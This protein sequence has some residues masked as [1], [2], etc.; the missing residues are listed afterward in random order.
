[1]PHSAGLSLVATEAATRGTEALPSG[2]AMAFRTLLTSLCPPPLPSEP[3]VCEQIL[4]VLGEGPLFLV[5]CQVR[6]F[7]NKLFRLC[8]LVACGFCELVPLDCLPSSPK[9]RAAWPV[10]HTSCCFAHTE[11]GNWYIAL[12]G[13]LGTMPGVMPLS[14]DLQGLYVAYQTGIPLQLLSAGAFPLIVPRCLSV[15]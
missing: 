6:P 12:L 10:P 11:P 9:L 14:A 13:G 15:M 8:F 1:M 4:W 5:W 7:L 3:L 2:K